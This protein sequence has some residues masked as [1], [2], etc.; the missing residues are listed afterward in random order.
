MNEKIDFDVRETQNADASW[1]KDLMISHWGSQ[2]VIVHGDV[3]MPHLLPGYIAVANSG[4][5]IGLATFVKKMNHLEIITLNSLNPGIGIGTALISVIRERARKDAYSRVILTT[6]NDNLNA[7]DFF[8]KLGFVIDKI[9]SGEVDQARKIKP[10]IPMISSDGI[11][12]QDE[13]DLE[14]KIE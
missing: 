4:E 8:Q 2:E 14:L 3:F 5:R 12:I 9:R 6:T 1:I 11:P 10:A 7:L 13:I